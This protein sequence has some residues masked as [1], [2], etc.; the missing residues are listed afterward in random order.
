MSSNQPNPSAPSQSNW[1]QSDWHWDKS[2]QPV[3]DG[4]PGAASEPRPSRWARFKR[5]AFSNLNLN[6]RTPPRVQPAIGEWGPAQVPTTKQKRRM[7]IY[8]G[9]ALPLAMLACFLLGWYVY[10]QMTGCYGFGFG[11]RTT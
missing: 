3:P 5:W 8:V 9:I 7:R 4:Q 11:C 6:G 10:F 2:G 1:Q